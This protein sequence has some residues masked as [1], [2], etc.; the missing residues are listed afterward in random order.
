MCILNERH[1]IGSIASGYNFFLTQCVFGRFPVIFQQYFF[2]SKLWWKNPG[3]W[4]KELLTSVNVKRK[5]LIKNQSNRSTFYRHCPV[6]SLM[7]LKKQYET[8][9]T[10]FKL[11]YNTQS[12]YLQ[13]SCRAFRASMCFVSTNQIRNGALLTL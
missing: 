5:T 7:L 10:R 2:Y 8:Y 12:I 4:K 9:C 1:S 3:S 13:L 11:K 6:P